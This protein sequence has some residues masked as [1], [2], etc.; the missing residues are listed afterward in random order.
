MLL[1]PFEPE[2]VGGFPFKETI[3][4]TT[5][6]SSNFRESQLPRLATQLRSLELLLADA[7]PAAINRR[8]PSGKWS[9]R[10]NLAHMARYHEVFLARARRILAEPAPQFPRYRAEEDPDWPAWV[11]LPIEEIRRRLFILRD[12]LI[13]EIQAI[14]PEDL[15][16]IGEHST[17]GE[18][19]LDLWLEFFLVHEAHHLYATLQRIREQST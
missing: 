14:R 5:S 2:G 16:R 15:S 11:S 10:E 3:M 9:A 19:P 6:G 1:S 4:A 18:M 7:T 8:P 12:E 13:R 17:F